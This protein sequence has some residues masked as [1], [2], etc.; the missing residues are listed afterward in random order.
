MNTMQNP[1]FLMIVD[2]EIDKKKAHLLQ[3]LQKMRLLKT[4]P[5]FQFLD[6][7]QFRRILAKK[8]DNRCLW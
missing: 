8:K 2:E 5:E 1:N 4:F 3:L 6:K 7:E